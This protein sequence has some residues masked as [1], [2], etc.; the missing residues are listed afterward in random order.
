MTTDVKDAPAG[1]TAEPA[2]NA[3]ELEASRIKGI[4]NLAGAVDADDR[5]VRHWIASGTSLEKVSEE[6]WEL[7]KK[8]SEVEASA[9]MIGMEKKEVESWSLFR[10]IRALDSGNWEKAGLELAASQEVQKRTNIAPANK[11]S[12]LVPL[13]VLARALPRDAVIRAMMTGRRDLTAALGSAGGY[14]VETDNVGFVDVLRNASVCFAMGATRLPGL[15]GNV[16]IPKRTAGATGYWLA[17]EASAITESNQ[18]FGQIAMSPKTCGAYNEISR[19]LLMQSAP[20][21]ESLVMSGLAL[22]VATAVDL[23]GLNGSGAAGQPLG[24]IGTTGV[25]SVTGTSFD[26]ADIIEFQTDVASA[27]A[28]AG[29]LGYV[30]TPTVAGLAKAR[31]KFAS[32]AAQLWEGRLERGTMDGYPAMSSNQMPAGNM[33]F[34]D[35]SQQVVGEWGVLEVAVNQQANFPAGIIGIRALYSVDIAI[36]IPA[37][38]SLMTGAT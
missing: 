27:N 15:Q 33:L 3:A 26:Y 24:I 35:W 25:G 16:T 28:L 10:A 19:Q 8:R 38:F 17:T 30:T 11:N 5:F 7:K 36:R 34:G 12:I 2:A 9:P 20:S 37:A 21:A 31:V 23:A 1:G 4:K 6:A 18:T 13:D 22:D 14:L 32:T 29:S